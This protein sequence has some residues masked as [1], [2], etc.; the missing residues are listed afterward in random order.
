V[1]LQNQKII[2]MIN[3]IAKK[4]DEHKCDGIYKWNYKMSLEIPKLRAILDILAR[5]IKSENTLRSLVEE[6][7]LRCHR[8]SFN[9]SDMK[10]KIFSR[11]PKHSNNISVLSSVR[12]DIGKEI[13]GDQ[14]DSLL[15]REIPC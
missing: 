11:L 12:S 14:N 9:E 10:S 7:N 1:Q 8:K 4:F 2:S 15:L 13:F 3:A 5:K 6:K